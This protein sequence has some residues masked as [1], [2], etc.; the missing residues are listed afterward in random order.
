[1]IEK[2]ITVSLEQGLHARPAAELVKKLNEFKSTVEFYAGSRK[3]NPKS[4]LSMM[5]ASIKQGE[6]IRV[7]V[8][9]ADEEETMDWIIKYL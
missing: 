7:A 2:E 9:G 4:V 5:T 1:M 8:D 3:F 6:T